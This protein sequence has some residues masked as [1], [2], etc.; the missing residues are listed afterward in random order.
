MTHMPKGNKYHAK[1]TVVDGITF[2]SMAEAKRYGHL[3]LLERAGAISG[4]TVHPRYTVW[5]G[6]DLTTNKKQKIAYEPDFVYIENGATVAEDVKGGKA[7]ITRLCQLK[8][9]MFRCAYPNI[10]LR[11]VE[12]E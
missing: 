12:R 5:E 2:D 10:E 6:I 3:K 8:A 11:I 7:T 4:L 1:K 9:K